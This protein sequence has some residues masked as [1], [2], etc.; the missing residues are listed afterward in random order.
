MKILKVNRF[1]FSFLSL[2]ALLV[3]ITCT[4]SDDGGHVLN[5]E[6]AKDHDSLLTL[7]SVIIK[8]Y[9]K[10]STF[11]QVVF[12][13][14]LRDRKQVLDLPLD[15]KIGKEYTVFIVGYRAGKVEVNKEVTILGPND[16]RSKD[17]PIPKGNDTIKVD[18][19]IPEKLVLA[20]DTLF[21]TAGSSIGRP[22][23]SILPTTASNQVVWSIEDTTVATVTADGTARGLKIGTTR[24]HVRSQLKATISDSAIIVVSEPV[25]VDR[26]VFAKDTTQIFVGGAAESLIVAVLPPKANQGVEFIVS[27]SSIINLSKGRI[28]GLAEGVAVVIARSKENPLKADTLNVTVTIRQVVDSLVLNKRTFTLYTGGEDQVL[29]A[30]VFPT[31]SVQKVQWQSA[32]PAVAKVDA[33]G[34]VSPVAPGHTR[35]FAVSQADSLK[36]DSAEVTVKTDSPVVSIGQD[37]TISMG[38]IITFQPVVAP[39]EYGLVVQFKWDVD[40][41]SGWDDS[42]AIVRAVSYKFD[43][44]KEIVVRFYVKDTEGNETIVSKKVKTVSGPVVLIT[45]P[46]NGAYFTKPE[47][48]IEWRIDNVAQTTGTDTVLK[49]GANIITRSAKDA[50]GKVFSTSVTVYLDSVPPAKPFVKGPGGNVNGMPTWTW[51]AG[52]GGNGTYRIAVD[53]QV[54]AGPEI[55]DTLYI[56]EKALPEG[57]HTFYV[58][59]RDAAGNW[60]LP[61]KVVTVVDRTGPTKPNVKVNVPSLSNVKKPVWTWVTGGGAGNGVFQYKFNSADFTTGA[62]TPAADTQFIPSTNLGNAVHTLYVRERDSLGNWSGIASAA[63]TIDTTAPGAPKILATSPAKTAQWSWTT[64][65]GGNGNYECQ[66][67]N[68]TVS[69]CVSNSKYDLSPVTQGDHTLSVREKDDAGNVSDWSSKTVTVDLTNPTISRSNYLNTQSQ[70]FNTIEA[71]TGSAGDNLAGA[72][73]YYQVGNGAEQVVSG[74]LNWSFTPVLSKG[75]QTINIRVEDAAKNSASVSVQVTY[76]P[77]VVFIRSN[78]SGLDNGSSWANAYTDLNSIYTPGKTFSTGSPQ[79]W[80]SK[81]NYTANQVNGFGLIPNSS[82][83]GGFRNDGTDSVLAKRDVANNVTLL[84]PNDFSKSVITNTW[85][86]S[87]NKS[88]TTEVFFLGDVTLDEGAFGMG[89]TN[90]T[91]ATLKNITIKNWLYANWGINVSNSAVDI[92]DSHFESNHFS[93]GPVYMRSGGTIRINN[94]V[95]SGNSMSDG[96]GLAIYGGSVCAGQKTILRDNTTKNIFIVSAGAFTYESNVDLDLSHIQYNVDPPLTTIGSCPAPF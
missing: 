11:S 89:I 33:G 34:R 12:H 42:A 80:V 35:V 48:K 78:A 77:D 44:E 36:K 30:K 28:T 6:I 54:F 88:N 41:N 56:S 43:Q 87:D 16:I 96:G 91:K 85:I 13:G 45:S 3:M 47:V 74:L 32:N 83:Y 93:E 37:T 23:L 67:D 71:F 70:I 55:K 49:D 95:I 75:T 7:D 58:Q 31:I 76:L 60:S 59:E 38:Q 4:T 53:S 73:V 79:F 15:P 68:G 63:V 57:T 65:N 52:G 82:L 19:A 26:V 64:G 10:D 94:T 24:L 5:V 9:S 46:V 8:V 17:L 25:P 69:A 81:G 62:S 90:A 18:P 1:L 51:S 72:K 39:Q 92:S 20:A 14:V 84:K 22:D 21:L 66:L 61:G 29:S 86:S 2:A 27:N 40:G 50:A